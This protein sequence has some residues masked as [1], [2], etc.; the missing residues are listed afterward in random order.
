MKR[1]APLPD[2]PVR[3]QGPNKGPYSCLEGKS[4]SRQLFCALKGQLGRRNRGLVQGEA[5]RWP[6]GRSLRTDGADLARLRL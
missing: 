2:D 5:W 3:N 4:P 1:T 6:V